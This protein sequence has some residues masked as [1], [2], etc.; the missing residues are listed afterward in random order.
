M[1]GFGDNPLFGGKKKK[2]N[3]DGVNL[4]ASI[5]VC[6]PEITTISYEPKDETVEITFAL[7]QPMSED[8]FESTANLIGESIAAYHALDG[9]YDTGADFSMEMQGEMGFLH[10]KRELKTLSRG[11]IAMLAALM[12]DRFG[13]KLAMD[14]G[15]RID[16]ESQAVQEELIDRMF[17][18]VQQVRLA[19]RLIGI[20]EED[21]VVV[22]DR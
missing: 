16:S 18:N 22:F 3:P 14:S 19:D 4:L 10:I 20:R 8:D 13:D 15:G 17:G 9:L 1:W 12:R 11:E 5:L 21:H 7:K 2:T 6:Y